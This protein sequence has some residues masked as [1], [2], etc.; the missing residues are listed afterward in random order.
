M[1]DVAP[2]L[3]YYDSGWHDITA[4][5]VEPGLT[6]IQYCIDNKVQGNAVF[7]E[8]VLR[9]GCAHYGEGKYKLEIGANYILLGAPGDGV[10]V[11]PVTDT[12]TLTLVDYL[13]YILTGKAPLKVTTGSPADADTI[14]G[15][16]LTLKTIED[17]V[18][19]FEMSQG[20]IEEREVG[21]GAG[22]T[23]TIEIPSKENINMEGFSSRDG[24]IYHDG[25]GNNINIIA[26]NVR[27]K[28]KGAF[29]GK[30]QE[31]DVGQVNANLY[32]ILK[33]VVEGSGFDLNFINDFEEASSYAS[34]DVT[35]ASMVWDVKTINGN[36]VVLLSVPGAVNLISFDKAGGSS[37]TTLSWDSRD[38]DE[39]SDG[40]DWLVYQ[41]FPD[42]R[43]NCC[44]I[45]GFYCSAYDHAAGSNDYTFRVV[46]VSVASDGTLTETYDDTYP[47][48]DV[49]EIAANPANRTEYRA[50]ASR[51][52]VYGHPL[53]T[54]NLAP[55]TQIT[56]YTDANLAS[57]NKYRIIVFR[58]NTNDIL[59][60]DPDLHEAA[61]AYDIYTYSVVGTWYL[62]PDW[63]NGAVVTIYWDGS[64]WIKNFYRVNMEILI[65]TYAVDGSGGIIHVDDDPSTGTVPPLGAWRQSLVY[66]NQINLLSGYLYHLSQIPQGH[67][68]LRGSYNRYTEVM[69]AWTM[70]YDHGG[71][72]YSGS[73]WDETIDRSLFW[74]SDDDAGPLNLYWDVIDY[75]NYNKM[76][77]YQ[78]AVYEDQK[79]QLIDAFATAGLFYEQKNGQAR[80]FRIRGV[81]TNLGTIEDSDLVN[82]RDIKEFSNFADEYS[83][84][85]LTKRIK[86]ESGDVI[87]KVQTLAADYGFISKLNTLFFSDWTEFLQ[88]SF[89]GKEFIFDLNHFFVMANTYFPNLGDLLTYDSDLYMITSVAIDLINLKI[90][91][92]TIKP[93]S[94][95]AITEMWVAAGLGASDTLAWSENGEDWTGAGNSIFTTQGLGVAF[96]GLQWVAGGVGTN[97]LAHS[98]DG[99]N[100]TGSGTAIFDNSG[101]NFAWNGS[102]WVAAGYGSVNTLAWS[103]NGEDWTGLGKTIFSTSGRGV[104]WNGVLFVAGGSGSTNTL[105][106]SNDGKVWTG[107]GKTI[108]STLGYDLAWNGSVFVATGEGSTN[109]LA[110]SPD[111]KN[112]TGLGKTIFSTGAMDVAWNGSVFVVVGAGT[113]T[114][115]WSEDGKVWHGLGTT[116]FSTYG[117]GVCWNGTKFVAVGQGTNSLAWSEDGK[118]WTGEGT[119]PF[120]TFGQRVASKP[121]PQ[122]IPPR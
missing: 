9:I 24:E 75:H 104:A 36:A 10:K 87:Q 13:F 48:I 110:W 39:G 38:W 71:I 70:H 52:P 21:D 8:L 92:Q 101:F 37:I 86:K 17:I 69:D 93:T 1:A 79:Q 45:A 57:N 61:S 91:I 22:G 60:I 80:F 65:A 44:Y 11:D 46:K 103:E 30:T 97:T 33:D 113:N 77:L 106:W 23:K 3:Y 68:T 26:K 119:T 81:G 18:V 41:I 27:Y 29:L 64:N 56:W 31:A 50:R 2:K 63:M 25:L 100:W 15:E 118:T 47:A 105:A 49:Y 98:P 96:N 94:L 19:P 108:F 82:I 14:S 54:E 111:G 5:V 59:V 88:K 122:L 72:I 109:T 76:Y 53:S 102:L 90:A 32:N 20:S 74:S 7:L 12:V 84:K 58:S 99:K 120:E 121:A 42:Y 40:E 43:N 73:S 6:Q 55:F 51:F 34:V 117:R 107:L 114:I 67:L 16:A 28:T 4:D 83:L 35:G 85:V 62:I 66:K 89:T 78:R 95:Q 115:A 116:I 112:W